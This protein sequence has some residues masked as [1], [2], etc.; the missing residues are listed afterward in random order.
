MPF[1]KGPFLD[2]EIS[3]L[4]GGGGLEG[5]DQTD[6]D[7]GTPRHPDGPADVGGGGDSTRGDAVEADEEAPLQ[8]GL[9][10][11][12]LHPAESANNLESS[13]GTA[14]ST[15]FDG[16]LLNSKG[17]AAAAGGVGEVMSGLLMKS[18]LAGQE[19]AAAI[20]YRSV[21]F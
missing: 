5:E 7:C 16:A 15:G 13:S 2:I 20:L 17:L 14:N 11:S 6:Q 19:G 12:A 18:W 8:E 3:L 4:P 9:V 10:A 1:V 21:G